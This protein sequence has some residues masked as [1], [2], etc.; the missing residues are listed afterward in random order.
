MGTKRSGLKQRTVRMTLNSTRELN[1]VTNH[2]TFVSLVAKSFTV[3]CSSL[4]GNSHSSISIISLGDEIFKVQDRTTKIKS[5]KLETR[6]RS[7]VRMTKPLPSSRLQIDN[8]I[9]LPRLLQL[10]CR[11]IVILIWMKGSTCPKAL[12][13]N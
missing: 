7:D 13:T 10:R 6:D 12:Y 9:D 11:M 8:L 1:R 4:P 2:I 3:L 5:S